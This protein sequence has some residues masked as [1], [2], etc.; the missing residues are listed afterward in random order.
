MTSV[1]H[2]QGEYWQVGRELSA[3]PLST[4]RSGR[5]ALWYPRGG[6]SR[7]LIAQGSFQA[8]DT[9]FDTTPACWIMHLA[10]TCHPRGLTP[11]RVSA[12]LIVS[13][14]CWDHGALRL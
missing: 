2:Y 8:T 14:G 11:V 10:E 1:L 6:G 12:E 4:Q 7:V 3:L 5:C 13:G 9:Q